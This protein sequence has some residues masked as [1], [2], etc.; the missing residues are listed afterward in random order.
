MNEKE[1]TKY[2]VKKVKEKGGEARKLSYEGR[3]GAPDWMILFP[4]KIIFVELKTEGKKASPSQVKEI[5]LLQSLGFEAHVV[6]NP[7]LLDKVLEN[8]G[9][10]IY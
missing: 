6:D 3:T 4:N 10:S 2:L 7:T 5:A 1:L 8:Y 9:T